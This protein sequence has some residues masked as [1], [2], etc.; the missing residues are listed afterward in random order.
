MIAAMKSHAVNTWKLR[1]IFAFIPERLNRIRFLLRAFVT[2]WYSRAT[3]PI[4]NH[5]QYF[6]SVFKNSRARIGAPFILAALSLLSGCVTASSRAGYCPPKGAWEKK[7]PAEAGFDATKLA[8]VIAWAQTQPTDWPTDFSK[9]TEIFGKQLG[10]VPKTRAAMNGIIL[11]HGY[12]VAEFG[13]VEAVDPSYSMAKSYLSTILGLTIDR[14]MIGD[15]H[16]EVGLLVEDG[17]YDMPHNSKV[18]WKHHA[19]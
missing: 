8:R 5:A 17:G 13:D 10:P 14:G 18:T 15:V 7:S 4:M 2:W 12:I 11:R 1:L 3:I 19:I 6:I 16:D 9:Q